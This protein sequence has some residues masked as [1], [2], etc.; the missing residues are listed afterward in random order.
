[1][2]CITY[3]EKKFRAETLSLI[4]DANDILVEYQAQGFV[5]TLRQL[6]YQFVARAIIENTE[7]SYKRLGSVVNDARLAGL[8]DWDHLTDRTRE[9]RSTSHWTSPAEII[10]ACASGF[11]I[12]KWENQDHRIEVW[13]EKDALI[14]VVRQACEPLD[15][16]H[17][18]CRGYVSQSEM[19]VAAGRI[20]DYSIEGK[21][22]VIIHLGDHDPSGIDMSRDIE[23]RLQM[24]LGKYTGGTLCFERIAL[25]MD[26]VDE[27]SPPPN[28]A[29]VTDSR[30]NIYR[31]SFGNDSWELD[32]LEPSV[33]MNLIGE[34][35]GSFLEPRAWSVAVEEEGKAK[36]T[37]RNVAEDWDS[38]EDTYSPDGDTL[39]DS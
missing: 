29:K 22:P 10:E 3:R 39:K 19:W 25:N 9:L 27:Y 18:S 5:L 36:D 24:F 12:D 38:I 6:Y 32:A 16:P 1:M 11:N 21:S 30:F 8:I 17:F 15:I 7:R 34:K 2:S 26:Q 35:V 31:R 37:L 28:P 33:I 14:D 20:V 23:D 4:E 13:V